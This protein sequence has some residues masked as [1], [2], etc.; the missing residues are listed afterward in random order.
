MMASIKREATLAADRARFEMRDQ[1][2]PASPAVTREQ[3]DVLMNEISPEGRAAVIHM[4]SS[5]LGARPD[6]PW[7]RR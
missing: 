6:L 3:V 2:R 7:L 5:K 4:A 1:S